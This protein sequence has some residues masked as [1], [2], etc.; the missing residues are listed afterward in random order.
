[1][2]LK[3]IISSIII[4]SIILYI[5][6]AKGYETKRDYDESQIRITEMTDYLH[7]VLL[8][9]FDSL[10][11]TK[12]GREI[13]L[14]HELQSQLINILH[15]VSSYGPSHP[16]TLNVFVLNFDTSEFEI[17]L[18]HAEIH[19]EQKVY[20]DVIIGDK[21]RG[22]YKFASYSSVYLNIWA[23]EVGIIEN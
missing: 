10:V 12:T 23:K 8:E 2:K 11:N 17:E 1:M 18:R 3:K 14:S 20:I 5:I 16:V 13:N 21:K 4:I 22:V 19:G 9:D 7:S 6:I 15:T